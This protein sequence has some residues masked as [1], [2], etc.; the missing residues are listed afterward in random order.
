MRLDS[1]HCIGL[2]DGFIRPR[3]R[4][5]T[6]A[7]QSCN[8]RH[9]LRFAGPGRHGGKAQVPSSQKLRL[10]SI[11]CPL[12]S[13]RPIEPCPHDLRP[14]TKVCLHCRRAARIAARERRR[15]MT[16]RL[17]LAA[18][19]LVLVGAVG[20]AGATAIQNRRPITQMP[21][22]AKGETSAQLAESPTTATP[23]IITTTFATPAST[24]QPIVTMA[25]MPHQSDSTETGA[26]SSP[27]LTSRPP[28]MIVD[29]TPRAAPAPAVPEGR[30][31]LAEGV[32]AVRNGQAV[33]VHFDTP[34]A[35]TRRPEKFEQIVRSTLPV[36]YGSLA[37]SLLAT[38]RVGELVPGGAVLADLPSRG[39]HLRFAQGATLAL[40]PQTREGRDGP[41][42]VAYRAILARGASRR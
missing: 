39:L 34:L 23:P 32:F 2:R 31:A 22:I 20:V 1:R 9:P 8:L 24:P 7:V 19:A 41:L 11:R 30:T 6:E 17:G 5:D 15:R 3:V 42:V 33:T 10:L 29:S 21:H 14:G 27:T 16:A 38:I 35:R 12:V 13:P 4:R 25:S 26:G 28:I 40:W 18:L 36:V 37:D